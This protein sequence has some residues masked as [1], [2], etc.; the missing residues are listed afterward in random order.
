MDRRKFSTAMCYSLIFL[1]AVIL[2][3]MSP[4]LS[5]IAKAYNLDMAQSGLLFTAQF[6]GFS[7]FI[8]FGGIAADRFGKKAVL[9]VNLIVMTVFIFLFSIAPNYIFACIFMFFIGGSTGILESIANA[10]VAD[11]NPI[12]RSFYINLAQVFF[13]VGA[14]AGP[15]LL[16]D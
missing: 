14:L 1:C 15:L 7:L 2:T 4:L 11:I 16:R 13:G 10:L 3:V 9:S 5:E 6:V 12:K 8:L